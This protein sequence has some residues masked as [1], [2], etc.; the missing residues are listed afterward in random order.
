MKKTI[1]ILLTAV[2]LVCTQNT[3]FTQGLEPK[4]DTLLAFKLPD[5]PWSD[6]YKQKKLQEAQEKD[7]SARVLCRIPT[8]LPLAGVL[9]DPNEL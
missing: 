8:V 9:G 7:A 3:A 4:K 5:M 2:S 1:A 6:A